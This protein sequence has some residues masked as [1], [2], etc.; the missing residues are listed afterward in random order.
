MPMN[1]TNYSNWKIDNERYALKYNNLMM[2][3]V[4][5]TEN[6]DRESKNSTW[7]EIL[8]NCVPF[9]KT[10]FNAQLV[11]AIDILDKEFKD[12]ENKFE[13]ELIEE[14]LSILGSNRLE[15]GHKL[16]N[17]VP[18][19]LKKKNINVCL[20]VTIEVGHLNFIIGLC[21]TNKDQYMS[22]DFK[23]AEN[24]FKAIMILS[25]PLKVQVQIQNTIQNF[26]RSFSQGSWR[27]TLISALSLL[28]MQPDENSNFAINKIEKNCY[29]ELSYDEM[30]SIYYES[31]IAVINLDIEKKLNLN[32]KILKLDFDNINST[33]LACL[34][35]ARKSYLE[36]FQLNYK[37]SNVTSMNTQ[38]KNTIRLENLKS[39]IF[40]IKTYIK[41]I[42]EILPEMICNEN[43]SLITAY[44]RT[45][46]LHLF[47]LSYHNTSVPSQEL[48]NE[49]INVYCNIYQETLYLLKKRFEKQFKSVGLKT[50]IEEAVELEK[51]IDINSNNLLI[52][53]L[54][55]I[56]SSHK[57]ISFFG[58]KYNNSYMKNEDQLFGDNGN[59]TPA[60]KLKFIMHLSH[61]ILFVLHIIQR[62]IIQKHI[63]IDSKTKIESCDD[64]LDPK[65]CSNEV[66][67]MDGFTF[68][69]LPAYIIMS[70]SDSQLYI[71]SQ[72]AY[73]E[74]GI[75]REL[76]L[77]ERLK[78]QISHELPLY[79]SNS[80]YRDHIF[81]A[82]DVCLLGEL[83]IRSKLYKRG[84]S[85]IEYGQNLAD[86][87]KM[88]AKDFLRNWY[89]AALFH[90]LGYVIENATQLIAPVDEFKNRGFDDF[91]EK[92][93][94]GFEMAKSSLKHHLEDCQN[95]FIGKRKT[96]GNPL[97]F[98]HINSVDHGV[99]AWAFLFNWV[100]DVEPEEDYT[101]ALEAIARHNLEKQIVNPKK[102]P[103]TFLLLLCDHLQEW[104]RPLIGSEPLARSIVESL[105][106]TE[107]IDFFRKVRVWNLFIAGL[108]YA[109]SSPNPKK[110][111]D[112]SS[113]IQFTKPK[114]GLH[115]ILPH[116]EASR[117]EFEPVLSWLFFTRDFQCYNMFGFKK[118]IPMKITLC[119]SPSRISTDL[120][121][122]PSEMDLFQ[123]FCQVNEESAYLIDWIIAAKNKKFG[124]KY[125]LKKNGNLTI[126][127]FT[128][129]L[130]EIDRPLKRGLNKKHWTAFNNWKKLRLGQG[131]L[132]LNPLMWKPKIQ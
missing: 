2:G 99:A 49:C 95:I 69:D 4:H 10:T 96:V 87:I 110:S 125:T 78:E 117:V 46:W 119:H 116:A 30:K 89:L 70:R 21:A 73:F 112:V 106:Y 41:K 56:L 34:S 32:D 44:L 51:G 67:L 23:L 59:A 27:G 62:E 38:K 37:L 28:E 108:E 17:D 77:Y 81:H 47:L 11:F 7:D 54:I 55:N 35:Y 6:L 52:W 88:P 83:L 103:I 113:L 82:M 24:F 72:Y 20:L 29:N 3:L 53:F 50:E 91:V 22:E 57:I 1:T 8:L 61:T 43:N 121:W 109:D 97:D 118:V 71:L 31:L 9:L 107:K 122:Q 130:T 131:I 102:E 84:F 19:S 48:V 128:I 64:L 5:L 114:S 105:R 66:E 60:G 123:E 25:Q 15:K 40:K 104:G 126:E 26:I 100:N 16:I 94:T 111:C 85:Q 124:L 18:L 76:L 33:P 129:N 79:A 101:P 42:E 120:P 80:F 39:E 58:L 98:D 75:H 68:A 36:Y 74:I 93:T 65:I 45:R 127:R 86:N 92:M 132:D 115:F 90:D 13:P 12:L 63:G 14:L